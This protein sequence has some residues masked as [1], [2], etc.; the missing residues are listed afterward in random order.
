[1]YVSLFKHRSKKYFD[2]VIFSTALTLLFSAHTFSKDT[3]TIIKFDEAY[4]D[5]FSRSAGAI[6]DDSVIVSF[7]IGYSDDTEGES[8]WL[9]QFVDF[10]NIPKNHF[11][12]GDFATSDGRYIAESVHSLS[13]SQLALPR[14]GL[15][16][17]FAEELENYTFTEF[18]Y[19]M[20]LA[21]DCEKRTKSILV[22]IVR[23]DHRSADLVLDA[24]RRTPKIWL[25]KEKDKI[26][27]PTACV[28]IIS[29]MA[30][31]KCKLDLQNIDKGLY[32]LHLQQ[33]LL[34]GELKES[35]FLISIP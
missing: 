29:V 18:L 9:D 3:L 27:E 31:H 8:N 16:S 24:G 11:L 10:A 35:S 14:L 2:V 7:V 28:K 26:T 22:P 33:Q 21:I 20:K 32:R 12:C 5:S 6:N 17:K 13:S 30:S 34:T 15:S 1:M 25:Q 19:S 4:S 23:S